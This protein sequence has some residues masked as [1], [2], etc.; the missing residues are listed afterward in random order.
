MKTLVV[1]LVLF[2]S[3]TVTNA[4]NLSF[5]PTAGFG[6][7]FIKIDRED[8]DKHFWPGWNAGVKLVYSVNENWGVSGDIKFS[9]EGGNNTLDVA[10]DHFEWKYRSYYV[11]IPIQAVYFF[12]ELGNAVRP[13]ISLGPSVGFLV[14]G[15]SKAYINGGLDNEWKTKELLEGF[16]FGVTGAVG[17]NFKL[18]GDKWLNTDIAY[19]HGITNVAMINEMRNRNI[20]FNIG[21]TFPIGSVTPESKK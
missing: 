1:V 20:T 11:R 17:A 5:G 9:A 16:D 8:I 18:G 15:D 21:V 14:A 3:V 6:H 10:G 7:S 2:L 12:G 19:Y 13:K 4:Q